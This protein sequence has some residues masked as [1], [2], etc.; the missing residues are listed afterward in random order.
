MTNNKFQP[1]KQ[2]HLGQLGFQENMDNLL[3]ETIR[4]LIVLR[5]DTKEPFTLYIEKSSLATIIFAEHDV[6]FDCP[7]RPFS[8]ARMILRIY[9]IQKYGNQHLT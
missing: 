6:Q 7:A 9:K 4:K 3:L 2:T 1:T 5:L 8:C